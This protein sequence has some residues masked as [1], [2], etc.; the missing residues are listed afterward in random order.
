M[1][2]VY[3][4]PKARPR[5]PPLPINSDFTTTRAFSAFRRAQKGVAKGNQQPLLLRFPLL[6]NLTAGYG[7]CKFAMQTLQSYRALTLTRRQCASVN[8]FPL[9]EKLS[10]TQ[11]HSVAEAFF[12]FL[13]NLPRPFALSG[14]QEWART[15]L[16]ARARGVAPS[17]GQWS[18]S[19]IKEE[20][21]MERR[22]ASE[23]TRTLR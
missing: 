8:D 5:H 23:R 2:W 1:G 3:V 21:G 20:A 16:R 13:R 4:Q 9:S 6:T 12:F 10:L 11:T 19:A 18:W 22:D 15:R 17:H 14:E 7:D